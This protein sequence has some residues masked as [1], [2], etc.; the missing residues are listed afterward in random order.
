MSYDPVRGERGQVSYTP[1]LARN[2]ISRVFVQ[3]VK[4]RISNVHYGSVLISDLLNLSR[5]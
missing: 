4:S 3:T 2:G 5:E 1:T